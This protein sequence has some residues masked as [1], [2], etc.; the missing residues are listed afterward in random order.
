MAYASPYLQQ[1][2][3]P[4]SAMSMVFVAGPLSGLLV[5]PYIGECKGCRRDELA[6]RSGIDGCSRVASSSE[7]FNP[8]LIRG[9]VG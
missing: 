7:S 3:L 6:R 8:F 5:A 1:L 4:K 9:H 2:G